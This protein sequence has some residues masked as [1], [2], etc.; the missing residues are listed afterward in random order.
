MFSKKTLPGIMPSEFGQS[1]LSNIKNICVAPCFLASDFAIGWIV[2]GGRHFRVFCSNSDAADGRN[3]NILVLDSITVRLDLSR[4]SAH[5]FSTKMKPSFP[6]PHKCNVTL[7]TVRHRTFSFSCS[8][9]FCNVFLFFLGNLFSTFRDRH[10][11][12]PYVHLQL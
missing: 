11:L 8:T 2:K 3:S 12:V 7:H 1:N 6:I 5:L 9:Y 10:R 4:F